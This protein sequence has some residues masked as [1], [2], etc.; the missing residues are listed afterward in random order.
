YR[1]DNDKS[2]NEL[3]IDRASKGQVAQNDIMWTVLL[4]QSIKIKNS[5]INLNIFHTQNGISSAANIVQVNS[6]SNPATITKQSLTY[7]QRSISNANLNGDHFLGETKKWKF[8]WKVSPTYSKISDPDM[9][10]TALEQ[11][12]AEDGTVTYEL[13]QAVG[14]EIRRTF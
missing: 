5:K 9:R 7:N 3:Y 1:K 10:T 4:G 2:I 13:N 12:T 6:E 11:V 8:N 14:A